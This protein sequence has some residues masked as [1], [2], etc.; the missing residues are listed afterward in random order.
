M[1]SKTNLAV[2][3]SGRGSNLK[4]IVDNIKSGYL[5]NVELKAV[6]A[7]REAPGLKYAEN[8]G[9]PTYMVLQGDLTLEEHDE[10]VMQIL[11][12][13]KIDLICLAGYLQILQPKF[14]NK[15]K[16]KIMNIHPSLLPAFGNTIHAQRE[17]FDY[18]VKLSGCTVHFVDAGVD[19]GP[20]IIQAAV[21][22]KEGDSEE[23]LA[24]R[25]LEFE[26]TIYSKA[27]KLFSE[28]KLTIEG[29]KVVV[30]R[31]IIVSPEK[32]DLKI[33]R[34]IGVSEK[35]LPN[36]IEKTKAIAEK[37]LLVKDVMPREA[38]IMKQEMLALGGDCAVPKEC[39]LNSLVPL[40]VLIIGNE[41]QLESLVK[42]LKQQP[43]NLPI[44]AE[45]IK[46]QK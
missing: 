19:T 21:P 1:A 33:M 32:L 43:F 42:K 14:V 26:H 45:K 15:Y 29:R 18:G 44:I 46:S 41:K 17:A 9:V 36:F 6:V 30:K 12:K 37:V 27:I 31:D 20:I 23:T 40:D 2:L 5:E 10:K 3:I 34:R 22:V 11:E 25:I 8:F 24:S 28:N 16:W 38:I 39:V 4:V 35:A 13:H 7:N